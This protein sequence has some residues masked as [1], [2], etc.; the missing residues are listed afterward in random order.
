[1]HREFIGLLHKKEIK[2]MGN[3]KEV[4]GRQNEEVDLTDKLAALFDAEEAVGIYDAQE[5]QQSQ[6]PQVE[7][8]AE[9]S[10]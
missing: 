9:K 10:E 2:V 4:P 7:V 5:A 1:L 3:Y 8:K 6:E